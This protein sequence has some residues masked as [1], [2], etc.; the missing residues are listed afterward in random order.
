MLNWLW[1]S[2]F[3][4]AADQ[5]SKQLAESAI[6]LYER[7]ALLPHLNLTLI[8][9][10]GAAFSFL[11]EQSGWQRWFLSVLAAVVTLVLVIW[12][13]QLDRTSRWTA[14]SLSLIIGGAVGNLIDRLLFGHVI[15]F[16]DLYYGQWHWPAFNVADSAISIGVVLMLLEAFRGQ[17][18]EDESS[19]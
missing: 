13:K 15:D 3:I 2:L 14:M 6:Q 11:S 9:N 12:L 19:N 16:I 18:T 7:V 5:A 1:L 10:R 8:Y 17:K 4:V